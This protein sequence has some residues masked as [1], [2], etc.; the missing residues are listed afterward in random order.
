MDIGYGIDNWN[1]KLDRCKG[2]Y[3]KKEIIIFCAIVV[4]MGG[5]TQKDSSSEAISSSQPVVKDAFPIIMPAEK[6]YKARAY[7]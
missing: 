3:M 5:N 7:G 1:K 6:Q 2:K 4:Y